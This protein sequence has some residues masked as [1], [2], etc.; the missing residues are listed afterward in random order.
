MVQIILLCVYSDRCYVLR[1]LDM[2]NCN[3][4]MALKFHNSYVAAV[5]PFC[6]QQL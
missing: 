6:T 1:G 2:T 3:T 4:V 5:L